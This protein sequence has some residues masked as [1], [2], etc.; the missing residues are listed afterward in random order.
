V[1]LNDEKTAFEQHGAA[2]NFQGDILTLCTCKH[3]MRASQA[4]E[5]WEG[6]WL[7]G[8]TSRTIHER[9]HW[10]FYLAKIESAFDSHS[11]LWAGMRAV[12]RNA[13]AAH[14]HYLGDMFKPKSS[15]A[16]ANARFAPGRYVSPHLHTHRRRD[17][18]GWHDDWHNDIC[19]HL[20]KKGKY[21]HPPLLVADP[22]RTFIWN[23]PRIYFAEDHCRNYRKWDSLE[24]LTAMLREATS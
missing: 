4:G 17:E 8:V 5:D 3:Q 10:L 21:R 2:P 18:G 12:T 22:R 6:V 11:D 9:K 15:I 14:V 20:A 24:Q 19:Y 1:K 23:K 13:K 16:T 7:A